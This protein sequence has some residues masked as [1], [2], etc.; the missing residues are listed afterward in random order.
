MRD[1]VATLFRDRHDLL[2]CGYLFAITAIPGLTSF[3]PNKRKVFMPLA[4]FGPLFVGYG[5]AVD[6]V[7]VVVSESIL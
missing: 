6:I 2:Q 7:A 3:G 1:F 5:Q 4:S